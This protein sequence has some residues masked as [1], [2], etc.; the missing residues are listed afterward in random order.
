MSEKVIVVDL[1]YLPPIEFFVAL[2]DFDKVLIE[3]HD[4]YQKQTYRNRAAVRLTNKVEFLSIPVAGGN[5]KTR[6]NEV[7]MDD[8]QKWKNVHLRGIKSAYGKAPFFEFIFPDLERIY[9]AGHENLY[10]FNYELLTL[11]LKFLK[12]TVKM[13]ET[14]DYQPYSGKTDLRGVIKAKESYEFRNIYEPFPYTQL[15]G[16]DFVPNLSIMDLLF[17]EGQNSIKVIERSKKR[18][19]NIT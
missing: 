16:L 11:C 13:E 4:N 1:F 17:C 10:A 14:V 18:I 8:R 2:Q 9:L 6:Y 15:F 7:K 12:A 5:K 3:K 19:M